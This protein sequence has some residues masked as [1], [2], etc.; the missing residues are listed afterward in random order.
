MNSVFEYQLIGAESKKVYASG[1][2]KAECFRKIHEEYPSYEYDSMN[3]KRTIQHLYP[4][5]LIIVREAT[6]WN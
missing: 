1:S 5:A 4:E 2:S 3:R 6:E